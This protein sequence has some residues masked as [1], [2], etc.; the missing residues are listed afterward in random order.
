M[1]KLI[2][3]EHIQKMMTLYKKGYTIDKIS[4]ELL[5]CSKVISREL[6]KNG[7]DT[8]KGAKQKQKRE[9][10]WIIDDNGCWICTSHKPGSHGY[11]QIEINN[12]K[13]T[14]NRVMYER[15]YGE[16]PKGLHICHKCDVRMCINP[17]HLFAGTSADNMK[18]MCKKGRHVQGEKFGDTRRGELNGR[19]KINAEIVKEIRENKQNL[20][21]KQA[22]K[23]YGLNSSTI[24][25]IRK[26]NLW[27]HVN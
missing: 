25:D 16:I 21:C 19:A 6:R 18:D 20:T 14:L 9:I 26:Y 10:T 11:P 22:G 4:K 8:V 23:M 3:E 5:I 15:Y 24:Y 12:A 7:I 17:E 1:H 27:K 2:N 13:R